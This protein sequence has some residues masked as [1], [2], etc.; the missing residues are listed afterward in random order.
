[1]PIAEIAVPSDDRY[2]QLLKAIK[3]ASGARLTIA[4]QYLDGEIDRATAVALTQKYQLVSPHRAA[5]SFSFTDHSRSPVINYG[6]GSTKVR[7]WSE[8]GRPRP[9]ETWRTLTK[10]PSDPTF[11]SD[12]LPRLHAPER[13]PPQ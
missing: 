10:H 5:Q 9:D 4:Q 8:R 3:R 2:W 1:M 12:F 6:L 11:P 13:H 7:A